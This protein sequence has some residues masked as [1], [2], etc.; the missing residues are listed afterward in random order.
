MRSTVLNC[1]LKSG[2]E[3]SNTQE[4]ADI[5]IESLQGRDVQVETFRLT[6]LK[7]DHGVKTKMSDADE[8]PVVHTALLASERLHRE[9]RLLGS[10]AAELAV[11]VPRR[12]LDGGAGDLSAPARLGREQAGWRVAHH[13]GCHG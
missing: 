9:P 7:I 6:D 4:L 10:N 5:V 12:R 11:R 13:H 1:S 8:W 2:S 3:K